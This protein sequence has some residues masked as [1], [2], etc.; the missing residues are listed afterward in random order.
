MVDFAKSDKMR[1]IEGKVD[2]PKHLQRNKQWYF[3]FILE[4]FH[5][6]DGIS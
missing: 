4:R 2:K 5:Q 3:V 6:N 1:K